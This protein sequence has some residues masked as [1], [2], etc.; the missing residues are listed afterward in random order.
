MRLL[1]HDIR[2]YWSNVTGDL[3]HRCEIKNTREYCVLGRRLRQKTIG[4]A[5]NDT[6]II[7][8]DR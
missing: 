6:E 8:S 3:Y 7:S 5:S 4:A 2:P 1:T